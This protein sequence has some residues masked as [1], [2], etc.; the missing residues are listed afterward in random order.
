VKITASA[1]NSIA[2]PGPRIALSLDIET[3]PDDGRIE[4]C[5]APDNRDEEHHGGY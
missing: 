2:R 4:H 1:S 5:P 3:K